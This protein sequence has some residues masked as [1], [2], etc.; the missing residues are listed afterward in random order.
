MAKSPDEI[1]AMNAKLAIPVNEIP[2]TGQTLRT[3]VNGP[4]V[5]VRY[6]E[7][8][9]GFND[10]L[11]TTLVGR[12]LG[13]GTFTSAYEIYM[14]NG[15]ASMSGKLMLALVWRAGH[16]I[17]VIIEETQSTVHCYRNMNDEQVEVGEVT[18]S[19]EDA[20]RAGLMDK[21]TYE[22]YP[23]T[24]LTWRAVSMACRIYYPD[25]I[26]GVGHVPEEVGIEADMD[27]IP[28]GV[29]ISGEGLLEMDNAVI[30][31]EN[32]LDA[33]VVDEG[34]PNAISAIEDAE[35]IDGEEG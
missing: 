14:V 4:T 8:P 28:E 7:S 15:Q 20:S 18:F 5:P 25:V 22:S 27:A 12:E 35:V 1:A 32:V 17:T 29:I 11:A 16:K 34:D 21:G 2:V 31:L 6:R 19:I 3:W 9:T 26:L 24:M 13:V 23:K 10:A 30:E 33:E